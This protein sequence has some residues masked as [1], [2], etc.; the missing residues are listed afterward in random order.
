MEISKEALDA[1]RTTAAA[2]DTNL[3]P[4]PIG[5][6][7]VFFAALAKAQGA[8]EPVITNKTAYVKSDKGNYQFGYASLAE[9]RSK[10]T[11]H[12]SANSICLTQLVTETEN[13]TGIRTILGH[14]SGSMMEG[15]LRIHRADYKNVKDFGA[16]I[17][18]LRRYVVGAMLGIA[19]DEDIENDESED[20]R[21]GP[22]NAEVH[23]GMRDATSIGAL[24]KVMNGLSKE[25]RVKYNDYYNQRTQELREAS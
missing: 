10:T 20:D 25:D 12:L 4:G 2:M 19:A 6:M 3:H 9:M 17:T 16:A 24:S 11:P 7:G 14:E 22:I 21:P 1:I 13:V 23:P 15:T 5:H 8:F 18:Y